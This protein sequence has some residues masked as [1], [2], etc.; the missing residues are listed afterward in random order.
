MH[1][2]VRLLLVAVFLAPAVTA[3]SDSLRCG[4][5]LVSS[6]DWDISVRD[7][8]G[9]PYYSERWVERHSERTG[10]ETAIARDITFEDWFLDHGP[11][12]FLIRLRFREGR[13]LEVAR[14]TRR[15]R[16]GAP[17]ACEPSALRRAMTAGELVAVCGLPGRREVLGE[18]VHVGDSPAQSILPTRRERWV[19]DAA[20]ARLI[21]VELRAGQVEQWR[22]AR[23]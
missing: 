15:G 10:P 19:Y 5:K 1:L 22:I 12:R 21:E 20:Q 2:F 7:T 8:C 6:G 13:L 3:A 4:S 17:G 11:E 9:E 14:L 23:R 16:R 18:A